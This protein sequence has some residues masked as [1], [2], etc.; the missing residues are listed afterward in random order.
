M[1]DMAA[2]HPLQA[3]SWVSAVVENSF[4]GGEEKLRSIKLQLR[5]TFER[6]TD[7]DEA[8]GQWKVIREVSRAA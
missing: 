2:E 5:K 6:E 8:M 7:L 3:G 1:F 4:S